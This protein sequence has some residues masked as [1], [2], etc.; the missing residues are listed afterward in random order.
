MEGLS[1]LNRIL[2]GHRVDDEE[3][4]VRV[5]S[6]GHPPHLVHQHPVD[7]ETAGGVDDYDIAPEAPSLGQSATDDRDRIGRLGEDVDADLR[8]EHA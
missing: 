6:L 2:A 3:R 4:V 5:Q 7:G 8:P 1:G